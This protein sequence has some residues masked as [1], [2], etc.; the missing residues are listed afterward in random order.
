MRTYSMIAR[1]LV[2]VLAALFLWSAP[3][4][5]GDAQSLWR[6]GTKGVGFSVA[7]GVLQLLI[8]AIFLFVAVRGTA[9]RWMDRFNVPRDRSRS[10]SANGSPEVKSYRPPA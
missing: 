6:S 9:P 5:A 1:A 7:A 4:Y 2:G 8:A 10:S 3:H